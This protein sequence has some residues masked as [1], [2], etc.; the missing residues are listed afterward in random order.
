M[1]PFQNQL[2]AQ[3]KICFLRNTRRDSKARICYTTRMKKSRKPLPR[4][5]VVA[6][7]MHETA[8]RIRLEGILR[9][10]RKERDWRI[11]L[12]E[13][14]ESLSSDS[15]SAAIKDGVDGFIIFQA[16]APALW[17]TL[18]ESGVPTVSLESSYPPD[19]PPGPSIR[20]V[21]MDDE[22]LG[23]LAARHLTSIGN[24]RAF[25]FVPT[26]DETRWSARREFGYREALAA[27]GRNCLSCPPAN[28]SPAQGEAP[29]REWLLTLPRPFA[30]FAATD[31]LAV[32]VLTACRAARID[33]PHQAAVLGTDDAEILC[34]NVSPR[35]SSIRFVTEQQGEFVARELEKLMDG[36]TRGSR[37]LPWSYHAVVPRESTAPIAPAAQLI[38]RALALIDRQAT[39]GLGVDALAHELGVSR[40]LLELR[41]R[42]FKG[43]TVAKAL[44]ARRFDELLRRLADTDDSIARVA[45]VCGF[46]DLTNLARRFK[47]RTGLTMRAWRQRNA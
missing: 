3:N 2:Y 33:V 15:V 12:F 11:R 10:L 31:N 40:R 41:F 26:P 19:L 18:A 7:R 23:R 42:Q 46:R 4:T 22:G 20:L 14:E 30:L 6:V 37:L 16:L 35:L 45:R 24:F 25:A 1:I 43:T 32:R 39:T 29:L 8:G 5:V 21:R 44:D 36:Q 38:R 17:H 13:T 28:L 27:A 9:F 47:S 34:D